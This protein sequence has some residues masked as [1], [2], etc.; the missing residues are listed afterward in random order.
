[1]AVEGKYDLLSVLIAGS[2]DIPDRD[3]KTGYFEK[4]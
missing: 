1:M 2:H 4:C 3:P